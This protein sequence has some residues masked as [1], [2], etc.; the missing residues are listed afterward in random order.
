MGTFKTTANTPGR[1][2]AFAN[3]HQ[4]GNPAGVVL[5]D[6]LPTAD[7]MQRIATE[8]GYSETVFAAPKGDR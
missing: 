4:G 7:E 6:T 1:I 5:G 3:G 8:I 2:A